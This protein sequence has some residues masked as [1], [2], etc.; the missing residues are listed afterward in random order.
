MNDGLSAFKAMAIGVGI[1]FA[2][3]AI[4]PNVANGQFD[5]LKISKGKGK[6]FLP[7]PLPLLI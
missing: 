7:L 5:M 3:A 6:V 4:A 1:L 2:G